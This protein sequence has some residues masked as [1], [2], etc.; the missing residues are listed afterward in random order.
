MVLD[1]LSRMGRTAAVT[2][3]AMAA[4]GC[5]AINPTPPRVVWADRVPTPDPSSVAAR[6]VV[7]RSSNT[8]TLQPISPTGATVGVSYAYDMP[9]CGIG[10]PIDVDGSFWDPVAVPADPVAFD[11]LSGTVKLTAPNAAT[12]TS[13]A[14][15]VLQLTRHTGPKEFLFCF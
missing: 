12:F 8:V 10:S 5:S 4:V 6:P 1:M 14:G 15:A 2:F 11:G 3:V 7:A 9:H 13:S